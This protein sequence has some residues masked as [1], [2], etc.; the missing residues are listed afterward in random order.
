MTTFLLAGIPVSAPIPASMSE[1]FDFMWVIVCFA[2]AVIV[3]FAVRTMKQIDRN[4]ANLF[5]RMHEVETDLSHLQGEHKMTCEQ[6]IPILKALTVSMEA[7]ANSVRAFF[8][9][10]A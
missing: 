10:E 8:K 3:W 2:L 9:R 5:E 7:L 6:M 4:Q 1:H